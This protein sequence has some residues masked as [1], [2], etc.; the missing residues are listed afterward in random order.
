M[1]DNAIQFYTTIGVKGKEQE[2]RKAI[3][4][5]FLLVIHLSFVNRNSKSE[6]L[7][8]V[9]E[10]FISNPVSLIFLPMMIRREIRSDVT[11][12]DILT[13]KAIFD[14]DKSLFTGDE[15]LLALNDGLEMEAMFKRLRKL[16]NLRGGYGD[17]YTMRFKHSDAFGISLVGALKTGSTEALKMSIADSNLKL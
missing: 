12:Q 11:T 13:M 4:T 16:W 14:A 7:L 6:S 17:W 1:R 3:R 8:Y 5:Y 9:Y 15:D 10:L 2:L